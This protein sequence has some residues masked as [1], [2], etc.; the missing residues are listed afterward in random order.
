MIDDATKDIACKMY[1]NLIRCGKT[2][3][4]AKARIMMIIPFNQYPE[5]INSLNSVNEEL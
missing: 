2:S 5:Y 3:E 4:Q 1:R